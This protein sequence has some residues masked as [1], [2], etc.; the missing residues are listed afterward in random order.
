VERASKALELQQIHRN[1]GGKTHG[2]KQQ[3]LQEYLKTVIKQEINPQ[4]SNAS[5]GGDGVSPA[6]P[7]CWHVKTMRR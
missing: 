1:K 7:L 4:N 6:V 3:K 2:K 5:I